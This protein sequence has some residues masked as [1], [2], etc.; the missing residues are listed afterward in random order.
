MAIVVKA[1]P[2]DTSDQ[3][4]RKF[5]KKVQQEQILT[6][7][8]EREYYKKPSVLKKEKLAELKRKRKRDY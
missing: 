2:T 8:K 3:V 1:G 6:K 4:I 7:I 5:K